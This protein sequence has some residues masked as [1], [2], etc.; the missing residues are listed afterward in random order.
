MRALV[1]LP[2]D[3]LLGGQMRIEPSL[4]LVGLRVATV[5]LLAFGLAALP[6]L[7]ATAVHVPA[8]TCPVDNPPAP[9]SDRAQTRSVHLR[10]VDCVFNTGI[11]GGFSDGTYRPAAAVRRDQMAAFI[12]RTLIQG[13]ASLPAASD[14]GFTDI[15]SNIHAD[16]IN[17]LAA[18]GVVMG[19][20]PTTFGPAQRV[21]R[22]QIASF[23]LR[24]VALADGVAVTELQSEQDRFTDVAS[25]NGHR[26]NING[27]AALGLVNGRAPR[28]YDPAAS[29]RRDEMASF[30][31]RTLSVL[32]GEDLAALTLRGD[33]LGNGLLIGT[34]MGAVI[35]Q[36]TDKLGAPSSDGG[37]QVA[38]ELAGPEQARTLTWENSLRVTFV[39]PADP[40]F[41]AYNYLSRPDGTDPLAL[42]TPLAIS[43]ASTSSDVGSAYGAHATFRS[44]ASNPFG[45][46]WEVAPAEGGNQ[47]IFVEDDSPGAGV[48]SIG[49][50]LL[51]CE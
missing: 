45:A 2:P 20:S 8:H 43:L 9:F 23:V 10:N 26:P 3:R 29:A 12:A 1:R 31:I 36:L 25:G 14:Q 44:S 21:R 46:F 41:D 40:T 30:L 51:F 38:C 33:G 37:W 27:A 22:D 42:A 47:V 39:N 13:G 32:L 4:T 17:R 15:G 16:D 5:V 49:A 35:E 19:T 7:P 50:N 28:T 24:A 34:P 48:E 11:T 18:A 6:A